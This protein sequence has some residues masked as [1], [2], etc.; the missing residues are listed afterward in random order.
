MGVGGCVLICNGRK[1]VGV[2][3][4]IFTK[5]FPKKRS[6]GKV[7]WIWRK[8][9]VPVVRNLLKSRILKWQGGGIRTYVLFVDPVET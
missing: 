3:Y 1:C 6:G 9:R 4:Y 5:N 8:G 2:I 7:G